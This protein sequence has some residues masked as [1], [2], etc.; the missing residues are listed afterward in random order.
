MV[1]EETSRT[2]SPY[3]VVSECEGTLLKSNDPF[4]YFML[5]AFDASGV[6]RFAILLFL[7]P[8]T[9]LLNVFSY[10]NAALKL[11]IFVATAGLRESDIELVSRI[12][13]PKFYMDDLSM[14]TWKVFSSCKKRIVVTRMPRVIVEWFAKE[15]LSAQEV[16]GTE[17]IVNRFGFLTGL[18]QET[19]IDTIVLNRVAS[20][21]VDRKPHLGLGRRPALSNSTTFL[22]LCEEQIHESN[23]WNQ[24]VEVQPP[25]PVI[26][27]DGGLVKRPTPATALTILIWFPFGIIL[28]VIR[29]LGVFVLPMWL[30]PYVIS[31]SGCRVTVKGKPPHTA[32]NSGGVLFVCNHITTIDPVVISYALG[33]TTPIV[34]IFHL[35]RFYDILSPVPIVRFTRNRDVDAAKMKQELAKGD[36]VVCPEGTICH[37]PFLLRFSALFAE[38]TDRIVPVA[39]SCRF[40]FFRRTLKSW[41]GFNLILLFM[42]PTLDYEITFLDQLPLEATCSSGKSPYDVAN[43]VQR[44]LADTLGFECTELGRK[45]KYNILTF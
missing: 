43:N 20:L 29:I 25:K 36:L 32:G 10:K 3:S 30:I 27:H 44:V 6:I 24:Q 40:G 4:S 13:L 33:H 15:H 41:N 22:S 18:I 1:M 2:P 34:V 8:V 37:Q 17:L 26:F 23:K 7:W 45:A 21:F 39:I 31:L 42:N 12:V 14:D 9:T 11:M 35:S 19:D 16:I 38:L 5:L 28:A